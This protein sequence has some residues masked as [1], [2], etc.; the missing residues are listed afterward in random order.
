MNSPANNPAAIAKL[1]ADLQSGDD[2]VRGAAWQEAGPL[3]AAAVRTLAGVAAHPDFEIARAAR[4]AL[5]K[6]VRHAGR[7][8]AAKERRAVQTALLSLLR[9]T[10]ATVRR[11]ALA[12]LSEIGD[13][14]AVAP[15]ATL[16]ADGDAGEAA[17]CALE[18]IPDRRAVRALE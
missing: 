3:G 5:W 13:A 15:I 16:L 6:I 9:N 18:R 11:E 8:Q 2:A 7:P 12:M 14:R 17:R 4:R 1:V 10:P